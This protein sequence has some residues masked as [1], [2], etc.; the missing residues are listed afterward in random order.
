MAL[1]ANHV[2]GPVPMGNVVRDYYDGNTHV[3]ICDD[4]Y[5][6]RSRAEQKQSW[7]NLCR[8]ASHALHNQEIM[9]QDDKA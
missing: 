8:I 4:A 6:D 2:T 5:R 1:L 3:I 7:E 9:N